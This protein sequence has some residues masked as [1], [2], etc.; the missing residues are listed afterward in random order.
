[1]AVESLDT[2][3]SS[4][5][6][7]VSEPPLRCS[8]AFER[9]QVAGK[10]DSNPRISVRMR[11]APASPQGR[12]PAVSVPETPS[13]PSAHSYSVATRARTTDRQTNAVSFNRAS[14]ASSGSKLIPFHCAASLRLL[15][16][17][18][19]Q[20][21]V[22]QSRAHHPRM[23]R[24]LVARSSRHSSMRARPETCHLIRS[25]KRMAH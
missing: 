8:S 25:Q 1:M 19:H 15:T 16:R 4:I 11:S 14:Q 23:P 7:R 24:T 3:P 22:S 6:N 18:T 13:W 5:P 12:V 2:H 21:R 10:F 9:R 17:C 20:R